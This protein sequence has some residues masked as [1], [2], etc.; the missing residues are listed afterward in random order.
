MISEL[1]R[2]SVCDGIK[3]FFAEIPASVV[4]PEC[5]NIGKS[6][7]TRGKRNKVAL[8]YDRFSREVAAI[9]GN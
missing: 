8:A 3:V 1:L 7:F 9:E 4:V 6:V 5:S 2:E